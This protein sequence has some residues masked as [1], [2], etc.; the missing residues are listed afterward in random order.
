MNQLT[1]TWT[2]HPLLRGGLAAATLLALGCAAS[3]E[4]KAAK[5]RAR[6]EATLSSFMVREVPAAPVGEPQAEPVS[7]QVGLVGGEPLAAD[8]VLTEP[9][10]LTDGA[11]PSVEV[12]APP[13]SVEQTVVLDVVV[14][15]EAPEKLGVLTLDISQV[16]AG[17]ELEKAH[18]RQTVDVSK[19]ERG[20]GTQV[21]I[22]L[23]SVGYQPGD[24][25]AV[26]VRQAI[27]EAERSFY[28][29][30]SPGG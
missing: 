30:L 5:L 14:R 20:P 19:I 11:E 12:A 6:Y 27:P 3:P 13:V 22:T 18:Y 26:E 21:S 7:G 25:F 15:H 1:S 28:P 4:E 23:E 29:E 8:A 16:A 10:R 9:T 17:S 2:F 24:G